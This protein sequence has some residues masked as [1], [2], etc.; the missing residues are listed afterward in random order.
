MLFA[1]WVKPQKLMQRMFGRPGQKMLAWTALAGLEVIVDEEYDS[2]IEW[3]SK[4]TSDDLYKRCR[5]CL[6][7]RRRTRRQQES[8]GE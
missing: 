8:A 3:L 4:R 7:Q 2:S 6:V 1:D 5:A